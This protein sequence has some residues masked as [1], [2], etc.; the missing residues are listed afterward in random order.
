MAGINL[1][2]WRERLRQSRRRRLL[3]LLMAALLLAMAAI[4]LG[5]RYFSTAVEIQDARNAY[6]LREIAL[7]DERVGEV[8]ILGRERQSLLERV[9]FIQ[10]LRHGRPVAGRVFEQLLL[11]LPD[12]VHLSALTMKDGVLAVE[13]GAGSTE[14]IS[15]LIRNL[16]ESDWLASPLLSEVRSDSTTGRTSRFRLVIAPVLPEPLAQDGAP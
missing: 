4:G 16:G 13:G 5:V 15:R 7:L 8:A 6:L 3:G 1:L 2:P 14:D 10:R 9:Q 12:G 11:A